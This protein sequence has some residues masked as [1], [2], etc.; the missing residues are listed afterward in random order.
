MPSYLGQC[1]AAAVLPP[2]RKISWRSFQVT[3]FS[4]V[5]WQE[6]QEKAF[7]VFLKLDDHPLVL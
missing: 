3:I 5:S 1:A 7:R 6:P 2:D 4:L